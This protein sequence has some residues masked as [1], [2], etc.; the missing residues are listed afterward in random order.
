VRYTEDD[1]RTTL[2]ALEREA[3]DVDAVLE[4]VT[5]LLRRRTVHRRAFGMAAAVVVVA[6]VA[7][8]AVLV[9]GAGRSV[10]TAAP[11]ATPYRLPFQVGDVPGFRVVTYSVSGT[12]ETSAWLATPADIAANFPTSPYDLRVFPRGHV[13]PAS[14]PHGEPVEVNGKPG[15]YGP[16]MLCLCG[17]NEGVPSV[18][19]EYAPDSWALVQSADAPASPGVRAN[20]MAMAEAVRF[21]RTTPLQVPFRIGHLPAGL[22]PSSSDSTVVRPVPGRVHVD[23]DLEGP[24]GRS[25]SITTPPGVTVDEADPPGAEPVVI[26][27]MLPLTVAVDVGQFTVYVSGE[28]YPVEELKKVAASI[29]PVSDLDDPATWLDADDAIPLR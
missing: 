1:L 8:G 21:D 19:W 15:F 18:G 16:E 28:G 6:A 20:L 5:R 2:G 3:P 17:S 12:G 10:E 26:E 9:A 11:S 14:G 27:G 7:V 25:L 29:S 24:G 22:R 13:D 23:V 4:G